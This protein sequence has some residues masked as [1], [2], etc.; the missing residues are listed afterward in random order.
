MLQ[1]V[2]LSPSQ[3]DRNQSSLVLVSRG[4]Q[5]LHPKVA[6]KDRHPGS[7]AVRVDLLVTR[8]L[9]MRAFYDSGDA[10]GRGRDAHC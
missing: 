5:R 1:R 8:Q 9:R 3:D 7:F 4:K 6:P 2:S 10:K